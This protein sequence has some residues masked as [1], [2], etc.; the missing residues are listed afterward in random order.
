LSPTDPETWRLLSPY[1]IFLEAEKKGSEAADEWARADGMSFSHQ[2]SKERKNVQLRN[3]L[4][5]L[6]SGRHLS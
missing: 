5:R 1:D 4:W 6:F 2:E 3:A